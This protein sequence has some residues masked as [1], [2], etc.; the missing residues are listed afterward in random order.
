MFFKKK[1]PDSGN[2]PAGSV[3]WVVACLGNPG[4]QYENTRHNVGFLAADY[5]AERL[6]FSISRL[7]FRSLCGDAMIGGRRVLFLKP[8]TF[9]NLSGEAV[10]DAMRFYKV[11]TGRLIVVCDDVNFEVG[12]MR[13]R[14]GGSDGGQN[15]LK[16]IIYHQANDQFPRLRIGVGKKP[17]PEYDLA[18]WVLSAFTPGEAEILQK[19]IF[20]R[21]L[22]GI[23]LIIGGRTDDAMNLCNG[24]GRPS[25]AQEPAD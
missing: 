9:M 10:R 6:G 7:K 3:E 24:A 22:E 2:L 16:N 17:S 15:G 8:S 25:G 18:R 13:V 5:I 12:R 4:K 1:K 20:P 14:R 23:G 19:E 21:V 11:P